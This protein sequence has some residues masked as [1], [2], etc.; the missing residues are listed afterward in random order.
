MFLV[1]PRS[2][3]GTTDANAK[4]RRGRASSMAFSW[5]QPWSKVQPPCNSASREL[6]HGGPGQAKL[7]SRSGLVGTIQGSR[8]AGAHPRSSKEQLRP[9]IGGGSGRAAAGPAWGYPFPVLPAGGI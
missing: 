8:A 1:R 7:D 6:L 4:N 5:V 9:S 2:K 3:G